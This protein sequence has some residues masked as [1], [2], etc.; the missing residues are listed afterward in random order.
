MGTV[1]ILQR[2]MYLHWKYILTIVF[3]YP[4]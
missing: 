2:D 1:C 3:R 4:S